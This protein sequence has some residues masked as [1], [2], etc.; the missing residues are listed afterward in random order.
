MIE[1]IIGFVFIIS[2]I[3]GGI[4]DRTICKNLCHI[5]NQQQLSPCYFLFLFVGIIFVVSGY[6][7]VAMRKER[8]NLPRFKVKGEQ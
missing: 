4:V 2:G 5:C 1:E 3:V 6:S 7:L 8:D